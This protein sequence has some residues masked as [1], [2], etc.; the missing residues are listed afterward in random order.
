LGT[1]HNSIIFR[2]LSEA[3][4]DYEHDQLVDSVEESNW[5]VVIQYGYVFIFVD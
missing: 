4:G 5:S 3:A 2:E 1:F